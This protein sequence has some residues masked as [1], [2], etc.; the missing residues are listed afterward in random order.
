MEHYQHR[1]IYQSEGIVESIAYELDADYDFLSFYTSASQHRERLKGIASL[2]DWISLI[3]PDDL[4]GYIMNLEQAG[5]QTQL[6]SAYRLLLDANSPIWVMDYSEI[7]KG[8]EAVTKGVFGL[9]KGID[10]IAMLMKRYV[11]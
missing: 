5:K 4:P 1:Q 7:C 8:E 2:N 6:I 11:I 9:A 10:E 3:A